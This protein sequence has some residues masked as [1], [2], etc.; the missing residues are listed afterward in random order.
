VAFAAGRFEEAVDGY[1]AELRLPCSTG[2]N[3][4]VAVHRILRHTDRH[5]P[6]AE[7]LAAW[8]GQLD[9]G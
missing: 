1:R 5:V 6:T 8:I 2:R 7:R 3:S 4:F 9:S